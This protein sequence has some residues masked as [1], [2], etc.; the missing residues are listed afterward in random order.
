MVRVS[1]GQLVLT[2]AAVVAAALPPVLLAYLQFGYHADT[3]A[4]AEFEDPAANAERVLSQA[5]YE[6]S[7]GVQANRSWRQRRAAAATIRGRLA[8]RIDTLEAAR[9][10]SGTHLQVRYNETAARAWART[11]W[12]PVRSLPDRR[13]GGPPEPRR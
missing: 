4:T 3:T 12:P 5:V 9:I 6:A 13:S 2:T 11:N 8:P 1:R 10:E 7:S